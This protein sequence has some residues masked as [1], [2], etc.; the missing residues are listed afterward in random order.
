[1]S[2]PVMTTPVYIRNAIASVIRSANLPGV[3][4]NVFVGRTDKG[5]PSEGPFICVYT[6]STSMSSG[7]A[8]CRAYECGTSVSIEVHVY[9]EVY[10]TVNGVTSVI[11]VEEQMDILVGW[12]FDALFPAGM[13][14]NKVLD[15]GVKNTLA[16]NGVETTLDGDGEVQKGCAVIS[17]DSKW[18][19][20]LPQK[21]CENALETISN[22]LNVRGGDSSKSI[23]WT[24]SN[25]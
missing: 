14:P 3:G 8:S 13:N 25:N 10:Q 18:Y 2:N 21:P 19:A 4:S 20:E 5:F 12:I 24:I 9:G 7:S 23:T 11:D 6:N 22:T 15:V 17:M 16:P 1:M